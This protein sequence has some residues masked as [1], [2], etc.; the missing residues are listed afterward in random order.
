MA[1]ERF[2]LP[3]AGGVT[4][5]GGR[6]V[7]E[8]PRAVI[9]LVHGLGEHLGRYD[10]FA[11]TAKAL[12]VAVVGAD[13]RGHGR[14]PGVPGYV[15]RFDEYVDDAQAVITAARTSAPG[16]PWFLMGHS[17]GGAVA[18]EWL[19]RRSVA[20]VAPTGV[21]LSSAALKIGA[22]VSPLLLALAPL[23]SAVLP[24]LRVNAIDPACISRDAAQVAAYA[25]DPLVMHVAPPAR[26]AA[27]L[28]AVVG[29]IGAVAPRLC[30]P[31]YA[32]HGT[33]DA[34]TDPE[35]TRELHAAWGG[36]DKTLR[37]WQGSL[38]EVLHDFDADEAGNDIL[39]WVLARC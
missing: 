20:E 16:V 26:T 2:D 4:L 15:E 28:L 22:E 36:N 14:S 38:H 35:G 23:I 21:V 24:G 12:G 13:L 25:D 3:S 1:F 39:H 9:A 37:L 31:L 6:S 7:P 18:I 29:R 34:L 32:M 33:G 10:A 27:E 30:F 19:S 17:M 5:A 8:S 11:D